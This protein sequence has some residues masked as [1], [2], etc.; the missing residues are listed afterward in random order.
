MARSPSSLLFD[1]ERRLRELWLGLVELNRYGVHAM[2]LIG[3]GETLAH[4]DVA[5]VP[6][7]FCTHDLGTSHSPCSVYLYLEGPLITFIER[8]P[9]TA[10]VKLGLSRI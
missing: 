1:V 6:S 3:V 8:G 4:E 2:A 7:T 5:E 10:G 9:S